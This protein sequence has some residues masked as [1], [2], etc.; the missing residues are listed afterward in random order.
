MFSLQVKVF[1]LAF[2]VKLYHSPTNRHS[3]TE[4]V[5]LNA[6]VASKLKFRQT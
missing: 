6:R 2:I 4:K 1:V 5:P 3:L